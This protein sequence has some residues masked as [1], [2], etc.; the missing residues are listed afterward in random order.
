MIP[1]EA[2]AACC[3]EIRNALGLLEE[4]YVFF[5]GHKRNSVFLDSQ[6]DESHKQQLKRVCVHKVE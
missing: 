5:S 6:K 4:L 2:T 3:P 1:I